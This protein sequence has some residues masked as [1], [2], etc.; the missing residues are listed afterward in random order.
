MPATILSREAGVSNAA[1]Q[2]RWGRPRRPNSRM[3]MPC[4]C[5]RPGPEPKRRGRGIWRSATRG[6]PAVWLSRLLE[7]GPARPGSCAKPG[8]FGAAADASGVGCDGVWRGV[9]WRSRATSGSFGA[10]DSGPK[11][12]SD[13]GRS[14]GFGGLAHGVGVYTACVPSSFVW[15]SDGLHCIAKA[16]ASRW[17]EEISERDDGHR[18]VGKRGCRSATRFAK[19]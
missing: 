9:S 5:I 15:E 6:S 11:T 14:Q 13:V 1:S 7:P 12:T 3:P 8:R 4:M 2:R 10:I 17:S 18:R 19:P 16:E